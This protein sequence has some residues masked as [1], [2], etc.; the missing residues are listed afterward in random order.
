V[1]GLIVAAAVVAICLI[2][3]GL[4]GDFLVDWLWFSTIGYLGVF[5]RTMVAQ[6]EVFCAIFVA[7]VIV[8]WVNGWLA[9]RFARSPWTQRPADFEWKRTGVVMLHDVL[10]F[11]CHRLPWPAMIASG[12]GLLAMLVASGEVHNWEV[13]PHWKHRFGGASIV[14]D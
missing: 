5:W 12:A 3:L 9:C 6:A 13:L 10:E 4:T 14:V 8:L 11:T 2:L 7:T 1:V